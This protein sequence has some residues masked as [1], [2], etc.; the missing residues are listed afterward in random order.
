MFENK[1]FTFLLIVGLV[2]VIIYESKIIL[3]KNN[4]YNQ[5]LGIEIQSTKSESTVVK[6]L[7]EDY[8]DLQAKWIKDFAEIGNK[9]GTDKVSVHQYQN[10]YGKYLGK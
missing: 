3:E 4:S 8:K 6:S 5:P 9:H 2:V 10:I 7:D 1:K